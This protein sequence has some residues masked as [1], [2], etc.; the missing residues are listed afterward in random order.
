MLQR[1]SIFLDIKPKQC[2]GNYLR[3]CQK[4]GVDIERLHRIAQQTIKDIKY[5]TGTV[6]PLQRQWYVA[7]RSGKNP[8][9]SV[10]ESP[11]YL[12]ELW[13]CWAVYSRMYLRSIRSQYP[14][15][16]T[17]SRGIADLGCGAG[18]TTAALSELSTG[19]VTGTNLQGTVQEKVA[20]GVASDYRFR[21]VANL[22]DIRHNVD[23]VFA[24]EYFEHFNAPIEHLGQV[25]SILKPRWMI[26]A[27]AF[28]ADSTGHFDTYQVGDHR[29]SGKSTS[30]A[31]GA[32]LRQAG[33][34]KVKTPFYNQRPQ[35]W[36]RA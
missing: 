19:K 34:T 30:R 3:R 7:L 20:Q 12:A 31:F 2:L 15:I 27:N 10:Y 5:K 21:V 24:S 17:Q 22:S 4:Q 18:F 6:S 29:I 28:N 36:K 23:L 14:G 32:T 26:I 25:L 35:V 9:Y 11:D 13:A 33:Y 8:D 16:I 1:K